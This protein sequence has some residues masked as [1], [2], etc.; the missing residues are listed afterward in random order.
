MRVL[1]Q[2]AG[3][4]AVLLCGAGIFA[5]HRSCKNSYINDHQQ[6]IEQA[7]PLRFKRI[8]SQPNSDNYRVWR[9]EYVQ[10]Q[11]SLK[12]DSFYREGYKAGQQNIRDSLRQ[13]ETDA[14]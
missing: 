6:K 7:D 10:M 3:I 13:A 5:A 11:D 4:G 14:R 9:K 1:R 12:T 8:M 2:Y